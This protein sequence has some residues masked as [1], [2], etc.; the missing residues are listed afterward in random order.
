MT[1]ILTVEDE[2]LISEYLGQVLKDA[3]YDVVGA[4]NADEAIEV[5]E[6]RDDIGL[7]ITDVNMPGS[8]DGLKLAAAVR[9]RWPPIQII[10]ATGMGQ[11]RGEQM[12]PRS[13]FLPKPCFPNRVPQ[14]CGT[15]ACRRV[16]A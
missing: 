9:G 14:Q 10:I 4:S 2:P 13:Q 7:V 15:S 8:T 6:A 11:P 12:P 1:V 16:S 3:G 5:L